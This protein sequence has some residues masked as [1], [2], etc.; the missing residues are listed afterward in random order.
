MVAVP[1]AG[2]GGMPPFTLEPGRTHNVL[3]FDDPVTGLAATK[4]YRKPITP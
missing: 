1:Q 4:L 3:Q 2:S